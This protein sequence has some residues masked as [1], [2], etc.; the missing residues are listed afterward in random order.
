MS[1]ESAPVSDLSS[2]EMDLARSFLP[3]WAK[4]EDTT[5]R[6]AR[7]AEREEPRGRGDRGRDGFRSD[8]DGR[9]A[10]SQRRP[11]SGR[12]TSGPARR[13]DSR[14]PGAQPQG[15]GPRRGDSGARGSRPER[16]GAPRGGDR[17]FDR[18]ERDRAP[19]A[20]VLE[21]W[22]VQFLPESHGVEGIARQM[23]TDLKAYPLFDL[24][25][26]VLEK[27]DRYRVEFRRAS[28]ESPA[29]YQV[30]IDGSLWTGEREAVA[31][32]LAHHLETFYRRE[33]VAVEPPKGNFSFVAV[34][35]MSGTVLGPPNYHDYQ[36]KMLRL[37]NERFANMPFETFKARIRVEREEALVQKWKE[38][39]SSRD[40]F[41]SLEIPEGGEARKLATLAD[42]EQ[43]F[44]EHHLKASVVAIR[45]KAI[46]PGPVALG[47]SAALVVE[48]ARRTLE[49]LRRFPLSLAHTL[50][51]QLT[52]KG[53]H[54]FKAHQKITYIS[55]VR[56]RYLERE[57]MPVA[58]GIKGI[59]S[60][61]EA[62]AQTPRAE[63]WKDLVAERLAASGGTDAE[64]ESAMA[65]DLMWLLREG[66]VIDFARKG[67]EAARRPQVPPPAKQ[68]KVAKKD[69]KTPI[70][71]PDAVGPE[72][73]EVIPEEPVTEVATRP[74]ADLAEGGGSEDVSET[75]TEVE[76][77][78]EVQ[79]S[80][81]AA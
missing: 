17:R 6:L 26:L 41:Y 67:F 46:V 16:S 58:D 59:L 12:G 44:R 50:G 10:R 60:Y 35:G 8:R 27:P 63:Q 7:L 78:T 64:A 80:A 18:G 5:E 45:E 54:I 55:M 70:I 32:V 29:V 49:E 24:A 65:T 48:L 3:S 20:P 42:V 66:H 43:D 76:P 1:D 19:Q 47:R 53:L 11:D 2:L 39:Q 14:K 72:I 74:G 57:N 77:P 73:A 62:H 51:R 28:P 52:S 38:E 25:W 36:A 21:G 75:M 79:D 61:L 15:A 69:K 81:P 9:G 33:R 4:E 23:K 37:Y 68:S 22:T 13:D 31:H 40:E 71:N 30:K 56:P 34:C